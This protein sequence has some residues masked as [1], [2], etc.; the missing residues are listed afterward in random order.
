MFS[1]CAKKK[2]KNPLEK[3]LLQGVISK[4]TPGSVHTSF[5]VTII[6]IPL[7]L[8]IFFEKAQTERCVVSH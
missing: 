4:H 2:K 6:L 5:C 8:E 3:L 1:F 7:R